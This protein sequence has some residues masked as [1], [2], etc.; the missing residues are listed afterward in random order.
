[1]L[2]LTFYGLYSQSS[3]RSAFSI[4]A[5]AEQLIQPDASTACL[6]CLPLQ[7]LIECFPLG[8]G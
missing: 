2:E 1:M 5:A 4:M 6:S 8:A 3:I 7:M